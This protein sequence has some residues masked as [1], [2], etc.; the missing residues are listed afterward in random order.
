MLHRNTKILATLG[1]A[2]C[3]PEQVLALAEAGVNVFRLNMSHGAHADVT[4]LHSA[5]RQA[6]TTLGR[7]LGILADLQGPKIRCG[8][9]EKGPVHLSKGKTF[10]FDLEE[11]PGS[12]DRVQL[13]HPEIFK[14]LEP[15][16][17]I[18]VND[19]KIR[20]S[21]SEV[22]ESKA[23]CIVEVAGAI[24]D[25][26]GINLP[27][28]LLPVSALSPKDRSDLEFVAQLDVDWIA[29]S[30]VQ[31]AQD[32]T[33]A[34]DL[35]SGRAK[36]V[37]KIEKPSAVEHFDAILDVSDGIMIAR[38]DLGVELPVQEVPRVQRDLVSKCRSSGKPVIVAT[39]MLESM[40]D[41][42]VPTRAEVSDVA[43][44]IY[45]G[46]DAVMLS[47]ET[48]AGSYPVEA[49][50][51]MA[52]VAAETEND[53]KY[54]ASIVGDGSSAMEID[55]AHAIAAAAKEISIRSSI[56]AICC[57]T[58]SGA[59][60]LSVAREKPKGPIVVLTPKPKT[61][62]EMCLV[63]GLRSVVVPQAE[64][65]KDAAESA[66]RAVQDLGYATVGDEVV[67][68]AGVPIQ[69]TGSTNILRIIKV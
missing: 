32:V 16:S 26:K 50:S 8:V 47:A 58:Q 6:E 13:P 14:V 24:S 12:V 19:G 21:V 9:F 65:F 23:H 11:S 40:I 15:G 25:R 22:S 67:M 33:E 34:R 38:G 3:K 18:L 35:I 2:S 37:S 36:I 68:T 48:A 5:I 28:V 57:F 20:L 62:R 69:D 55:T 7:P 53:P 66:S 44:A 60:A 63:W 31:R 54:Q 59:T 42:P 43:N 51:V 45:D 61:A 39:Q 4:K 49:V 29:L 56:A 1:P 17:S 30:F 46:A 27:D 64:R 41:A 10:T 52:S